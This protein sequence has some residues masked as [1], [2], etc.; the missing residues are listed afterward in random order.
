LQSFNESGLKLNPL[1]PQA[2]R[3][4]S[5]TN[6]IAPRAG[7]AWSHGEDHPIVVRGGFGVF[8]ARIPQIYISTLATDNGVNSFNLSLDNTKYADRQL[9]PTYPNTIANCSPSANF[10]APLPDIR[11]NLTSDVSA[12]AGHYRT[13]QVQQSSLSIEK[14]LARRTTGSISFLHV[15]G[16]HLIRARDVNLPPPTDVQYPVYDASGVN[17]LGHGQVQTFS[18]WQLTQSFTC[19]VPPCINPLARPIPQ[20]NAIDQFETEA[21][22]QYNG[23]T[24]SLQRRLGDGFYFRMGYTWAHSVDTGPDA[25]VAGVP[26][27]VQNSYGTSL[28]KASSVTDQRHR[29][30]FA[31]TSEPNPIPASQRILADIMNHWKFA[32]VV[33]VGSGRPY[34][35]KIA[36]DPN[37]DG[38]IQNDRLPGLGRNALVGP[39][40]STTDSRFSRTFRVT[41]NVRL[42]ML[43]DAFNLFNHLNKRILVDPNGF[44]INGGQFVPSSKLVGATYYPAQYQRSTS[45]SAATGA[46]APRQ[47]QVAMRLTF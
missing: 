34:D 8:Y 4:P 22:S 35:T 3:V 33:T 2:G 9:F 23:L 36:G 21:S 44:V 20:L 45:A 11:G 13:P 1:W 29:F 7:F 19:P 43:V 16:L 18:T 30:V 41:N 5:A 32:A 26:G 24:A 31:M 12:F 42:S 46:Y 14:E 40:Y 10:C 25:L 6:D 28:E 39:A 27:T 47:V 17:L 37:Q 38:N 15:H